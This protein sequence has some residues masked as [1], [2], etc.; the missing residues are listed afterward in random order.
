MSNSLWPQALQ[1]TR[2]L[3]PWD[4]PGKNTGVGCHFLLQGSSKPRDGT[5][6]SCFTDQLF[7]TETPVK[8]PTAM[9]ETW[10][11]SLGWEDPLEK[12]KATHSCILVWKIPWIMQSMGSQRVGHDWATFSSHL[13]SPWFLLLEHY[14][15][16]KITYKTNLQPQALVS[17]KIPCS[18]MTYWMY[19]F[20]CWAFYVIATDINLTINLVTFF[21]F[22]RWRN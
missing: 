7:T 2:L 6:V 19:L 20:L 1:T 14:W 15:C 9:W 13:G 4:F 21:S 5:Q 22:Y 17:A 11:W 18:I 8:N 10:V 12:G 3:C 16:I